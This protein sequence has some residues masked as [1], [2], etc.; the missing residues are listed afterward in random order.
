MARELRK[1]VT[2]LRAALVVVALVGCDR[3]DPPADPGVSAPAAGPSCTAQIVTQEGSY[4]ATAALGASENEAALR[5]RALTQACA[6]HCAR[7]EGAKLESC[8]P[9]CLVDVDAKK[10]GARVTC[11]G[12]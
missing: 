5:K 11:T 6:A 3:C 8:Q 10:I 9:R 2:S 4:R 7:L 1:R 12:F